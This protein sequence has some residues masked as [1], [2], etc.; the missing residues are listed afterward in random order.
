KFY[1]DNWLLDHGFLDRRAPVPTVAQVLRGKRGDEA[2]LPE[3]VVIGSHQK[4]GEA[5]ELMQRYSISQLPVVRDGASESLADVVGSL[6]DRDILGRVVKNHHALHEG[7]AK[8]LQPP[9]AT[10]EP[11]ASLDV[12]FPALTGR[13]NAVGHA[14][15]VRP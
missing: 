15:D 5:I 1:D 3:F 12:V 11:A 4:V 10:I 9:L 2:E 8:A 7:V 14:P 13:P 6:Q